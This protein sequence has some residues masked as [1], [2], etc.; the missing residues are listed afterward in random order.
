MDRMIGILLRA[1]VL[2][3]AAVTV[4]GGIWHFA[5]GGSVLP[6]YHVF[7]PESAEMHGLGSV[8]NG[9]AH[10]RSR[11]LIEL[12]LLMLIATPV[13]RVALSMVTFLLERDRMYVVITLIVLTGLLA[14]LT[15][16]HF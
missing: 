8:L 7:H 12:G 3:S 9:I 15:G 10:G 4:A 6:D 5:Q 14:S 2:A 16:F 13:A 1:G 11:S